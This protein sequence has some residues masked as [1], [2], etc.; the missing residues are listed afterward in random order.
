MHCEQPPR[1]RRPSTRVPGPQAV[2]T[3]RGSP[4]SPALHRRGVRSTL[5]THVLRDTAPD[6]VFVKRVI[7]LIPVSLQDGPRSRGRRKKGLCRRQLGQ[8][9]VWCCWAT[10][11][12]Q[13]RAPEPPAKRLPPRTLRIER[14]QL[15]IR[16][17]LEIYQLHAGPSEPQPKV[18]FS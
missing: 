4:P 12:L 13:L 10:S 11:Q 7:A 1:P 6:S 17:G 15:V 14:G 16:M 3:N 9:G 2:P 5:I 18:K 8:A